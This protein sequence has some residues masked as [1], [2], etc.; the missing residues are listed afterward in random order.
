MKSI[1]V[2]CALAL[3]LAGCAQY[4]GV[5]IDVRERVIDRV[6]SEWCAMS[7]A[8]QQAWAETRG[9]EEDTVAWL[10]ARC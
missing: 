2:A 3:G 7:P 6:V 8:A 1:A 5:G 4:G 9:Y 10:E